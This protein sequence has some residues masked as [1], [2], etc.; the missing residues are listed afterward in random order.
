MPRK[1]GIDEKIQ[2]QEEAL[3]KA[4]EKYDAAQAKLE[5]LKKKKEKEKEKELID[6]IAAS[7]K[8]ADEVIEFLNS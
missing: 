4:K 8:T 6:A 5:E 3:Q 7:G 1:I 2:A